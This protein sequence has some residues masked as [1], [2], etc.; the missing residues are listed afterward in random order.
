M[1]VSCALGSDRIQFDF[2][3]D[4]VR[5]R[6]TLK[7]SPSEANLKRARKQLEAIKQRIA[8]GT[9]VFAEEFPSYRFIRECRGAAETANLRSGLR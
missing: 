7:R 5:Y 9:F 2:A 1:V 3:F 4:G 6:P 8:T